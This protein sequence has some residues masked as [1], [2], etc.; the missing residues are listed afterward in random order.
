MVQPKSRG[1]C[2]YVAAIVFL[3]IGLALVFLSVFLFPVVLERV[4]KKVRM[5]RQLSVA[6]SST[7]CVH[8]NWKRPTL[9]FNLAPKGLTSGKLLVQL[10]IT[11]ST[12]SM[13]RILIT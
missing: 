6:L 2:R 9:Y 11:K 8:R 13:S 3:L 4:V 5:S 12:S 10:F 7:I 1:A